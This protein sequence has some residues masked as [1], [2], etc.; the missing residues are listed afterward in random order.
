[1]AGA[2]PT[3]NAGTPNR[4]ASVH[5][6]GALRT[7]ARVV[8]VLRLVADRP[9]GVTIAEI[10]SQLRLP[11]SSAHSVVRRLAALG[12]LER[13]RGGRIYG[14]GAALIQLGIRVVGGLSVVPTAR[15]F[16]SRLAEE[17]GEDVYLAVPQPDA[18]VYAEK[19]EGFHS[20]RLSIM[21]GEPRPLHATA[22]G[23]LY[24]AEQTPDRIGELIAGIPLSPFTASTI[25]DPVELRSELGK[26]RADGYAVT[27]DEH[28]HGVIGVAAPVR[29][30]SG[31]FVAAV[32]MALPKV[33]FSA[34]RSGL[35]ASV[36][37]TAAEISS[38]LGWPSDN[39]DVRSRDTGA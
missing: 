20:L 15:P 36:V 35:V 39:G 26:V 23:K 28:I 33:R 14:P 19:V 13:G 5:G 32:T 16:I 10:S 34:N 21:L 18:I 38:R 7:V 17:T 11:S 24:L 8:E 4:R 37:V 3:A 2:V 9:A 27:V 30:A 22:A 29:D 25:T 12:Y 31:T 1:M 6:V